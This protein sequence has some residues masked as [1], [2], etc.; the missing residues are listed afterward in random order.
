MIDVYVDNT[1]FLLFSFSKDGT[2]ACS[3]QLEE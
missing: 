1:D 2:A 3:N